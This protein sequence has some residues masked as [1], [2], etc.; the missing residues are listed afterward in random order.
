MAASQGPG[1]GSRLQKLAAGT[2][3]GQHWWGGTANFSPPLQTDRR[4]KT[5]E[6]SR[7]VG[8]HL[9]QHWPGG[10]T[11]SSPGLHS[12]G[13]RQVTAEQSTAGTHCG[14]H[15]PLGMT[16]I[17]PSLQTG[18]RQETVEQSGASVTVAYSIH[19]NSKQSHMLKLTSYMHCILTAYIFHLHR[20]GVGMAFAAASIIAVMKSSMKFLHI[21]LIYM[22]ATVRYHS[23]M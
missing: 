14:Q 6:Q 21:I 5:A 16:R 22:V 7:I 3:L 13:R 23:G 15:W 11:N 4:Q 18:S 8:T 17:S 19:D 12:I 10:T 2:H 20:E 1:S 9:G